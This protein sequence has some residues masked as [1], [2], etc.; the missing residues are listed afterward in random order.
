[1]QVSIVSTGVKT[2]QTRQSWIITEQIAIGDLNRQLCM[3]NCQKALAQ[4]LL[5]RLKCQPFTFNLILNALLGEISN[6][7]IIYKLH[8]PII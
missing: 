8:E 1:M 2:Y 5:M 4:E 3:F 7:D 6:I